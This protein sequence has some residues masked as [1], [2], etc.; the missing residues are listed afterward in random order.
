MLQI[1]ELVDD[2]YKILSKVGQ[3]GMSVVYMAI[4]EKANKTWAVKE[5]RKDG[6]L[7]YEAVRQGLI[8]ETNI[9]KNLSHSNLPSIIDV[10]DKEDSFI[11]IMDY[12]EGN[13]LSKKLQE[14]GA[15]P[16]ENVIKWAKQLCDVLGY[17]HSRQP[18]IIYRDMKPAN[19]MLKPDGNVML[20]D[21]GT[22]REFKSKNLEDTTC[23]GTEGYAAPEQ[24]PR[25]GR[26]TD[27]RTDIFGLGRT[28]Y[29]LVTGCNPADPMH[30]IVPI[31][32]I[33]PYLSNGLE[34][35]ILK[36]TENNPD[37]RYQS[38]A[39]LMYALENYSII[40][41]KYIKKQ[42]NKLAAFITTLSLSVVFALGGVTMNY[43]ASR[44]A[45]DSYD[46]K[47]EEAEKSSDVAQKIKL[48]TECISIPEKSGAKPAYMGLIDAY[49][50]DG[51]FTKD[52]RQDI[53]RLLTSNKD[54]LVKDPEAYTDICFE[55]GKLFWLY[56]KDDGSDESEQNN[57]KV[58]AAVPWFNEAVKYASKDYKNLGMAN[59]YLEIGKF[60]RDYKSS[61]LEGND[62]G[63]YKDLFEKF[64]KL[65][66]SIDGE[67]EIVKLQLA[68]DA[69]NA[70]EEYS[71]KFKN[72]GIDM[73]RQIN[74]MNRIKSI[75]EN[76]QTN[77]N[78]ILETKK[79]YVL[80]KSDGI[81]E[82]ITLAFGTVKEEN[83]SVD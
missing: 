57:L 49:K 81:N 19:I 31:R 10:I 51:E 11:I 45:N 69:G 42:K 46:V 73:N 75:A 16:Q 40:D 23:L 61:V 28:M 80:D 56:F 20:I 55:V 32:E 39:E 64:E 12:V 68:A 79:Q 21:F 76:T 53:E 62:S 30:K 48:Y 63:M 67:A 83:S 17:L 34:K 3:G 52:E 37:D 82:K 60:Y 24:Y 41:D 18:P 78:E 1:G 77:N 25:S 9:L 65:L 58:S 38:A 33:N 50:S 26:Q 8:A 14:F 4:N 54:E 5:V 72:D 6:V 2:K 47:I 74:M 13:S 22:A 27:G 71:T 59:V 44:T 35:I 70:L 66:S 29:H 36:C 15:Q 43:L 7:D